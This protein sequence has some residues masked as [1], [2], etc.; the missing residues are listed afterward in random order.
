MAAWY[1]C[2]S[3]GAVYS[4]DEV[5]SNK[6]E[7]YI[8]GCDLKEADECE[9]CRDVLPVEELHGGYCEECL[10]ASINAL[11]AERYL[12]NRGYLVQFMCSYAWGIDAR[13]DEA[14]DRFKALCL[15]EFVNHFQTYRAQVEQFILDDDGDSG[16]DDYGE[17]LRNYRRKARAGRGRPA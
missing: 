11:T 3:C 15:T 8:C 5:G 17:W 9:E 7:C 1:V 2:E 13:I 4:P 6:Y 16:M 14:N 12:S 10:R